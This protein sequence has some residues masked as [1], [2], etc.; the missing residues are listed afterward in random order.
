MNLSSPWILPVVS[1][2]VGSGANNL[3][4]TG[5]LSAVVVELSGSAF[6]SAN[7]TGLAGGEDGRWVILVNVASTSIILQHESISSTITN[8]FELYNHGSFTL[9][10]QGGCCCLLYSVSEQRWIQVSKGYLS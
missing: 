9:Q 7:L 1:G 10:P 3:N 5:M 2:D 4:P 6:L 8:Q